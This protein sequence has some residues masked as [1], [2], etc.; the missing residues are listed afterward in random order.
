M[1]PFVGN[2]Q[3]DLAPRGRF[4]CI[5][6]LLRWEAELG[7]ELATLRP[8]P[9]NTTFSRVEIPLGQKMLILARLYSGFQP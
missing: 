3:H 9:M 6:G 2:P 7:R 5:G 8:L 4:E 1:K